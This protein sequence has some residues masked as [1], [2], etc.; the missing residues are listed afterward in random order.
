MSSRRQHLEQD[1]HEAVAEYLDRGLTDATFW[2]HPA[3]GEK[4]PRA[5]AA[6]LKRMGVKAGVPDI[7]ILH[8]GKVFC[9]ELKAPGKTFSTVQ[10]GACAAIERAGGVVELARCLEHVQ[11]F[12]RAWGI[13]T[14][15]RVT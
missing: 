9:I 4:R 1:L 8:G 7:V 2:F 3:N 10:D 13:P 12:L 5:T 15:A 14:R 6:K 11:G